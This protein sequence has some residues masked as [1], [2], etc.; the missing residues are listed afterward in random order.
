MV[1][2][3]FHCAQHAFQGHAYVTA[4]WRLLTEAPLLDRSATR[5]AFYDVDEFL[6][7]GPD[8]GVEEAAEPTESRSPV[9]S[10]AELL[11]S[12]PQDADIWRLQDVAFGSSNF[13]R[14]PPRGTTTANFVLR[15]NLTTRSEVGNES[16]IAAP[17]LHKDVSSS[18][19]ATNPSLLLA[20]LNASML[21]C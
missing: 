7:L 11:A 20:C 9:S 18:P 17:V 15:T 1:L 14:K 16:N 6:V 8:A 2:N 19:C 21:K 10:L 12:F 13:A 5:V 4:V 3:D